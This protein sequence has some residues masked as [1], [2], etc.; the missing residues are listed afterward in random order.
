MTDF[1]ARNYLIDLFQYYICTFECPYR[2]GKEDCDNCAELSKF[3]DA[4]KTL[5]EVKNGND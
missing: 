3:N 2:L 5:T 1:E 4:L